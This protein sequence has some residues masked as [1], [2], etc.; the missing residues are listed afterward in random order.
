[1]PTYSPHFRASNNLDAKNMFVQREYYNTQTSFMFALTTH[2]PNFID[3][4]YER[5]FYGKVDR[6][7]TLSLVDKSYLNYGT[8]GEPILLNFVSEAFADFRSYMNRGR[9]RGKTSLSNALFGNFEAKRGYVDPMA[10]F[11]KQAYTL[12]MVFNRRIVRSNQI[13]TNMSSYIHEF[14]KFFEGRSDIFTFSSFFASSKI[15]INSTG[16]AV[17]LLEFD[18]GN[19]FQKNPLFSNEEFKFYV[20]AAANFGLRIDKNVPW[21]L[22]AD[23]NSGPMQKYLI[24]Y[25]FPTMERMFASYFTPAIF[26]DAYTL[27][28]LFSYAYDD[29]QSTRLYE[30]QTSHCFKAEPRF[31]NVSLS[32]VVSEMKQVVIKKISYPDFLKQYYN[33]E[34][35]RV[36]E[37]IKHREYKGLRLPRYNDFKKRFDAALGDRPDRISLEAAIPALELLAAY[38]NP[39]RIYG[40][41]RKGPL[42]P[43][44]LTKGSPMATKKKKLLTYKETAATMYKTGVSLPQSVDLDYTTYVQ[45]E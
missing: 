5:P 29:Y 20:Q 35:I 43:Q 2:N 12:L 34:F 33:A 44:Y 3:L 32:D 10:P 8:Q 17:D 31:K 23:L 19:D 22:I 14:L 45:N 4:W 15:G 13:I 28:V 7:G 40:P 1:M 6:K 36:L 21:R 26:Y 27:L 37:Q 16:L 18:A 42:T 39:A 11:L 38:Y 25:N 30:Y 24:K 41:K 9:R